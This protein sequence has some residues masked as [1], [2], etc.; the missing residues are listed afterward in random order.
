MVDMHLH[1]LYSDGQLAVEN[2]VTRLS[3]NGITHAVLT[4]HD[5]ILGTREFKEYCGYK[6][7]KAIPGVELE[8]YYDLERN[9][10][11]H[12]LCYGYKDSNE[13]NKYLEDLRS[14]RIQAIEEA[15]KKLKNLGVK[16]EFDDVTSMSCG[17]HLLINH[18]CMYLEKIGYVKSKYYAY[19]MFLDDT[20]SLH[21]TY[22]R[23]IVE[24]TMK[25]IEKVGGVSVLAHPQRI[26][27]DKVKLELYIEYLLKYGLYGIETY[28]GFN[29]DEETQFSEYVAE[30]FNLIETV[31]SDWHCD[32]DRIGFGNPKVSEEKE[33]ILI[34]RIFNE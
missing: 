14:D 13:L 3:E 5:T 2:L 30:K 22:P 11:L 19:N 15:I 4:D 12:I 26:N 25:K 9:R 21:I 7:I 20:S 32:E 16:V 24:D 34:K 29:T 23:I 17:R 28:Y 6:G 18:L 10:Y 33:K 27:M 1:S 8:T 31:G